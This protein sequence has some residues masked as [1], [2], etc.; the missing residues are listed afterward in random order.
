MTK[1]ALLLTLL[2]VFSF[3]QTAPPAASAEAEKKASIEGVVVSEITKEPLRRAEISLYRSG[4]S[5]AMMGGDNLAYSAVTDASG[6]FRIGNIEPGEYVL[7]HRKAGFIEGLHSF[8]FSTRSLKLGAGEALTDLRYALLPQAVVT[9]RVLDDEGEPVQGVG[10][11]LVR[12]RYYHGSQRPVPADQTQTNDR[13]EY[14]ITNVH[15]GKYFIQ[16]KLGSGG[17]LPP[18]AA[19]GAPGTAFVSTYYPSAVEFAQATRIEVLAGQELSGQDITLRKDKVVAVSGKVLNADGSPAKRTFVNLAVDEGFM[20]Y[21]WLGGPVDE[22]GNFSVRNVRPGQYVLIANGM[23][24]EK[25]QAAQTAVN[26]GD[27]DV[28]QVTLQMAPGLEAKGSIVLEGSDKKGFD[29][30]SFSVGLNPVGSAPFGGAGGQAKADGT[31]TLAQIMPGQYWLNVYTGSTEGYVKSI[32]VGGEE[33]YG[34]ELDA[35]TISLGAIRVVVRLDPASV[36]GTVEIPE[37]SR[38]SLHSPVA[39]LLPADPR[40]RSVGQ[41]RMAQIDQTGSFEMKGF[42]PGDY[43]AF[44]F[45]EYDFSSTDESEVFPAIESKGVK[46]SLSAGES[47]TLSLKLLPWP[48]QFADRLQ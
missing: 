21:P 14:R 29:F 10:V 24:G 37:E 30:S 19:G 6:K 28:T 9:G 33:V 41:L 47:K 27:V 26:V 31:F 8:G 40:M 17:P 38:A 23:D 4:K 35:S 48:E 15:P 18:M 32:L 2:I 1:L 7:N 20:S 11:M 5:A 43:L 13:G 46:V 45:E 22:K 3:G 42:R 12:L 34:K 25:R 36:K 44:A 39:I 16:A